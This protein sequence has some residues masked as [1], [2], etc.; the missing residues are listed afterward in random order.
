MQLTTV[1]KG[2]RSIRRF[3]EKQPSQKMI[4][5]ILEH[6]LWAPSNVNQQPWDVYVVTGGKRL[7][8]VERIK[9]IKRHIKTELDKEFYS[10]PKII[11][12]TLN[13]FEN[14]GNAP[15][16]I[17]VYIPDFRQNVCCLDSEKKLI[18]LSRIGCI[19]SASA[20]IQNICLVAHQEGLGTCWMT[21]PAWAEQEINNV[22]GIE[23]REL[24]AVIPIGIPDQQPP[25][26]PRKSDKLHWI[27]F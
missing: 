2:R 14:L 20:L 17:L 26:P 22:L 8:V 4:Q 19:Q 13:F 23:D 16:I 24:V 5:K 25:A 21:G 7:Q 3:K 18:E 10:N 1:L 27:G 9:N 6:A 11:R 15:V 12:L